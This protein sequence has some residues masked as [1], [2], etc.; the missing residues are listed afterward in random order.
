MKLS[1]SLLLLVSAAAIASAQAGSFYDLKTKTLLGKPAD[2]SQYRGKVSLVVNVASKC[3]FTPQYEGLEKLQREM[4]G[5]AFNVLGF[6][7]NDF[8][9]QEPGSPEE[10][11]QFCKLTYDVTFPMFEK[12]V[13]KSGAAQSP[14]YSFL[15]QSG[16]LPAWNFSKYVID[17]Q[18]RVTAFFPSE[19]TPDDPKVR[20]AIAKALA[21]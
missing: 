5:K 9:Q 4:K 11:A 2:L 6:P 17:K 21:N 18:G 7:S 14:V 16:H 10:I 8:G 19:V 20:D 12:V 1:L 13:T 15:G 3:G